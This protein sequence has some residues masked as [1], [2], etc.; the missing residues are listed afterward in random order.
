MARAQVSAAT[1]SRQGKTNIH[2]GLLLLL[3]PL[4]LTLL[5]YSIG[6]LDSDLESLSLFGKVATTP[7]N[8]MPASTSLK[9]VSAF[10]PSS[11]EAMAKRQLV[12][13]IVEFQAF[14]GPFVPH[15]APINKSDPSSLA[16]LLGPGMQ[17]LV[18]IMRNIAA[19][20]IMLQRAE[21]AGWTVAIRALLEIHFAA[22]R[23]LW[24]LVHK[25]SSVFLDYLV[26]SEKLNP[27]LPKKLLEMHELAN[28]SID[29]ARFYA[30]PSTVDKSLRPRNWEK[31]LSKQLQDY[32]LIPLQL[33]PTK[34]DPLKM[35][36]AQYLGRI[37]PKDPLQ[38][39]TA[40]KE[41][42]MYKEYTRDPVLKGRCILKQR[43]REYEE[44]LERLSEARKKGGSKKKG[45]SV[46]LSPAD[47]WVTTS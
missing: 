38:G 39:T 43:I 3:L 13:Q 19:T 29:K 12:T 27:D 2:S 23:E 31:V 35:E 14:D 20:S 45:I 36:E 10:I 28:S 42:A 46:K 8:N 9:A 24:M 34:T 22:H 4:I 33:P 37:L 41:S 15:R 26:S 32:I 30:F 40:M 1:G 5:R 21:V 25:K 47:G 18:E 16:E 44:A 7:S 17:T 11:P 6:R